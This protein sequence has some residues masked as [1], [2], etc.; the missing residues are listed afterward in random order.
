MEKITDYFGS[1]VFDDRV[2]KAR[3]PEKVYKSLKETIDKGTPLDASVAD[4][5][6]AAM[7]DWAIE[8][9]C[10]HYTHWFRRRTYPTRTA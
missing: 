4:S 2:M 9:G 3:L 8:H 6:A 7:K 10:T 5:V 1:M